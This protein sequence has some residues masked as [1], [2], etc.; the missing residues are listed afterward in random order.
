MFRYLVLAVIP[1]VILACC[2]PDQWEGVQ[3]VSYNAKQPD[4]TG[5][6]V[7]VSNTV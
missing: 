3:L 5:Y 7:N 4:G 6:H 2:S 1:A